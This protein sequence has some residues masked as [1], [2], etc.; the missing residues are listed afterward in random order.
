ML[1]VYRVTKEGETSGKKLTGTVS[2]AFTLGETVSGGTSSA[3]GTLSYGP[4]GGAYILVRDVEGTFAGGETVTG[5]TSSETCILTAVADETVGTGKFEESGVVDPRDWRIL[6]SYPAKIKFDENQ[7]D[8]VDDLRIRLEGLA[9]QAE[10][11]ADTDT[12]YL[13]PDEFVEVAISYLPFNRIEDDRL[14]STFKK[15]LAARQFV[16]ARGSRGIP[17]NA[18][19][20]Y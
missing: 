5:T 12:I 2:G 6:T 8:V 18:R 17:V 4:A 20:C 15:C 13:P 19:R 14:E 9:T 16:T 11:T 3:S 10:V 1:W 7:F